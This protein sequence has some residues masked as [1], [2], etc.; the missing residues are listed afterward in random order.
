LADL[1][2]LDETIET[3]APVSIKN[4]ALFASSSA[5]AATDRIGPKKFTTASFTFEP[6]MLSSLAGMVSTFAVCFACPLSE[7]REEFCT[8][9][10]TGV[11]LS[12]FLFSGPDLLDIFFYLYCNFLSYLVVAV[13]ELDRLEHRE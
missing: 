10:S 11:G 5:V 4:L 3:D 7:K 1:S 13:F 9:P 8:H 2:T 12:R 6:D